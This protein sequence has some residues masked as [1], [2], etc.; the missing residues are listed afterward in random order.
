MKDRLLEI[1]RKENI[2]AAAFAEKISVQASAISHILAGRNNP[3][4]EFLQKVLKK[5][6]NINAEWLITGKGNIYKKDEASNDSSLFSEKTI[7]KDEVNNDIDS[8]ITNVN[9]T[10]VP[11]NTELITNVNTGK[12][13]NITE[14]LNSPILTD[15]R[16]IDKI[17]IFYKDKKFK[18][19]YPDDDN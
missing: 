3:G 1:L 5:F 8:A 12:D 13:K 19:Y 15:N 11:Q 18:E 4:L 10:S 2:T 14:T 16:K 6:P 9:K 7:N 17:V